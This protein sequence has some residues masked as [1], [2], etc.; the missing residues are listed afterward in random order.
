MRI[1]AGLAAAFNRWLDVSCGAKSK[2]KA[3]KR[4]GA[5]AVSLWWLL[6]ENTNYQHVVQHHRITNTGAST[7]LRLLYRNETLRKYWYKWSCERRANIKYK[8]REI[9]NKVHFETDVLNKKHLLL[10]KYTVW[11]II[12]QLYKLKIYKNSEFWIKFQNSIK[13][14]VYCFKSGN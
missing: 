3:A 2:M 8:Q 10:I 13:Y 6:P 1:W 12:K 7:A 4:S 9:V 11:M 14:I 5:A